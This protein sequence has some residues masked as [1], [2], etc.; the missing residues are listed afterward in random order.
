MGLYTNMGLWEGHL[1]NTN[2]MVGAI[3]FQ[4]PPV[5]LGFIEKNN[6]EVSLYNLGWLK[7]YYVSQ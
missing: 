7:T 4:L 6:K 5:V 1:E 2:G 3:N